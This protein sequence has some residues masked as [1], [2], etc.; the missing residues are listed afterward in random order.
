MYQNI[1]YSRKTNSIHLWDDNKGYMEFPY[2][3]YCYIKTPSGDKVALSGHKVKKIFKW[4]KEDESRGILYESDVSPELRVLIDMYHDS[5]EPSLVYK[6]CTLDIEVDTEGSLPDPDTALNAITAITVYAKDLDQYTVFILD[7]DKRL[8]DTRTENTYITRYSTESELLESF[9][10]WW[11]DYYPTIVTGWNTDFF[12]IPYLYN[13]ISSILGKKI[14]N[15]LSPIG[16]VERNKNTNI[17]TLAGISSLDYLP[18]YKKYATNEEPSYSLDSIAIKELGKGKTKYEGS[19]DDLFK[20]DID[21]FI[22]YNLNDVVLV[23]EIDDKLKY[24]EL[25][26]SICH[27]GHVPYTAIFASSRYLEGA[28]LTYMK[29][30]D[31][32]APNKPMTVES[33]IPDID[34]DDEDGEGLFAGAYVKPPVPGRYEWL[35]CLDATSLYPSNIMT[36][37]ISPETIIGIVP[38]WGL[39]NLMSKYKSVNITVPETLT[40][41]LRSGKTKKISK[42]ELLQ[43]LGDNQYSIAGNG[44]IYD[45]KHK[46]L[47]P[48][49]LEKWFE[50][51]VEFKTLMKKA[52][53]SGDKVK[54]EYFD[55]RQYVT[56]I[57]LN[58]MYGVLGLKSFRFFDLANAEAVTLTG[59]DVLM[60]ADIMGNKWIKSNLEPKLL[61]YGVKCNDDYCIYSDTDSN[62]FLLSDF[63]KRDGTE[64]EQ[65]RQ[66]SKE[67]AKFINDALPKFSLSH[68]HSNY[69]RLVF[70]EE[71]AIKSG[72][73]IK[74]KRYAYHKVF[75]LES[76]QPAD[77]IIIKGLDVVRSNF[78]PLFRKSM[79]EILDDILKFT[80]KNIID[81][82]IVSLQDILPS[83]TILDIAKPTSIKNLE[84]YKCKGI[85]FKG[86]TTAHAKAAIAYNFL[87]ELYGLEKTVRG[88]ESGSKIKWVYLKTNPF[89]LESIAF[90]GYDDPVEV[91]EFIQK[92]IDYN[93]NFES[94]L[95]KKLN[96]FYLALG[97]G[98]IPRQNHK[99]IN[100]FFEF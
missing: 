19:L 21:K 26:R 86:G 71:S 44:A 63:I 60:F 2:K 100:S 1:Y 69:N 79:K 92:Y 24:I 27:K 48:S 82:K 23:K 76:E 80:P 40:L 10:Q 51:R 11:V 65:V 67:I 20:N 9:M 37:N 38:E 5:D 68:L 87:L 4:D 88:I 22:E 42:D 57:L 54:A 64:I 29:N 75:D 97:W 84:K 73:W 17:Y 59:Q 53:K 66:H 31:I 96:A 39:V 34:E 35:T 83:L 45:T 99:K 15:Q 93:K 30:L 89:N 49:I 61:D 72:F 62:Y 47:I 50:E 55:T 16:V 52:L 14:G 78:P 33:E 94:N 25:T 28:I 85:S 6:V 98:E 56:K 13:R 18:L 12:D 95:L 91:M 36:L 46:G 32:V 81:D 70:K 90:K 77:K 8:R 43:Y 41:E 74:K 58:S 7:T 3:K